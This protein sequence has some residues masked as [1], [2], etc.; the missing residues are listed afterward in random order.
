MFHLARAG[1]HAISVYLCRIRAIVRKPIP[2]SD[3]IFLRVEY[4]RLIRLNAMNIAN[5]GKKITA[6]MSRSC[7]YAIES[8]IK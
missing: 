7:Q 3:A 8:R 1:F 5:R 4:F 2:E 6:V